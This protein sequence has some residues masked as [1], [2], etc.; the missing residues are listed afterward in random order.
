MRV[1]IASEGSGFG[2]KEKVKQWLCRNGHEVLDV[3]RL[4]ED[5]ESI[6]YVDAGRNA[7][8]IV[9]SGQAERAIV[10][11]G[12]G[13][14]VSLAANKVKGV[15]CVACESVYSA[16]RAVPVVNANAMA[17]GACIVAEDMACEMVEAFINSN[18]LDG[19]DSK[20]AEG[21]RKMQESL[22]AMDK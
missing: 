10:I 6:S 3:G 18:F 21:L 5:D 7:A 13:A 12:T 22:R 4:C 20:E 8:Q 15:C 14:G 11:C 2:L 9:A 1:A 16:Q 19:F 17:I